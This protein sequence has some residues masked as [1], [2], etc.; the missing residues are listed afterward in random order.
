VASPDLLKRFVEAFRGRS[1]VY[2]DARGFCRNEQLTVDVF[3]RHLTS[4]NPEDHIGVYCML[5]TECSWG[6]IDIDGKDFQRVVPCDNCEETDE[7]ECWIDGEMY[8][9]SSEHDWERMWALARN[10]KTILGARQIAAHIE[11]TKNGY[12]VWVF[13]EDPT[14]SAATMRR[15]LM[16]A[17]VA[18]SYDPKEVNP[19]AEG[20]RPGTKGYGNFVRLPYGGALADASYMVR[21]QRVMVD[22]LEASIWL[23][24]FL[25]NLVRTPTF[26]LEAVAKLWTP[27]APP[28]AVVDFE[29]GKEVEKILPML[30]GKTWTVWHDGPLPGSDRSTTLAKLA[31]LC[32]ERGITATQAAAV[33][34]SAD[35]R[36]GKFHLR[37]DCDEQLARFIE[38]AYPE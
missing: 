17:C 23:E 11:R 27:P 35:E 3:E 9:P 19:K 33:V 37:D 34:K 5:G 12:H 13:P 21:R 2:G 22:G 20:P 7:H 28:Q 31:Y 1:D 32:A 18:L 15:A 26:R 10:L 36:W 8:G 30:D 29:A 14:V 4:T 25:D 6:C 24:D 16:A 38:R